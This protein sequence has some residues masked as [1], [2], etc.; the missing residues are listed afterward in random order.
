MTQSSLP[1]VLAAYCGSSADLTRALFARLE[2]IGAAGA[3]AIDIYRAQKASER[4]K[5]YRR[6]YVREAYAKK[7]WAM[8][9]LCRALT[10]HAPA[11]GLEWGWGLDPKTINFPHVLYVELP[12][13]QASFHTSERLAGPEHGKP[14]DGA[15]GQSAER[16]CRYIARVLDDPR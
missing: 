16:I 9:N 15:P 1:E 2:P 12:T 11:L 4:A 6:G 5:V 7:Q 14:W 10:Q 8:D 3:V 13:G